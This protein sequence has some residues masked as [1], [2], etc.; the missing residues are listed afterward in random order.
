[1]VGEINI[2]N[3]DLYCPLWYTS[4]SAIDHQRPSKNDQSSCKKPHLLQSDF[5]KKNKEKKTIIF[6][7]N[8]L[9][10]CMNMLLA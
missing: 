6:C 5:F 10:I 7:C 8:T 3:K 4:P 9:Y 1:M 2:E